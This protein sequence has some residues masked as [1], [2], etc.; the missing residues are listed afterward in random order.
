MNMQYYTTGR[1]SAVAL[2][3]SARRREGHLRGLQE[4]AQAGFAPGSRGLLAR[5]RVGGLPDVI[6]NNHQP[7]SAG[8][9]YSG[10][11]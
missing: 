4:P 5:R 2:Q 9:W 3:G 10:F 6:L 1:R 8:V 11:R 7:D